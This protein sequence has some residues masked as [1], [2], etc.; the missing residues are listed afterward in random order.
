MK[1]PPDVNLLAA[2]HYIQALEVQRTANKIVA[3]LGSKTPHIQ[4]LA[5]GGVSNPIN[6]DSQSTLT[7]ERLYDIKAYIDEL[8][9]FVNNAMIN[10]VAAVGALYAD[11]TKYDAGVT[12]YLS[13]PDL[14]L[15]TKGTQFELPGGYIPAADLTRFKPITSYHDAFFRDGVKEAVKHSWY[16]YTGDDAALHPYV[17]P[18]QP[19]RQRLP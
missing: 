16:D 2:T 11:W 6:P 1:L 10:D 13:V 19:G 12:N 4:N 14:P 15:D 18:D 17:G 3:I 8:G 5:V 9:D 7:L